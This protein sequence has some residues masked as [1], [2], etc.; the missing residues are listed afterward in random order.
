MQISLRNKGLYRVT[1]GREFKPQQH[2][3]K[4]KYLNKLNEAFGFVCIHISREL[5]FHLERLRTLKEVWEKLKYLFGKHDELRGH[6]L[7]NELIALQPNN[8]KTIQWFFSK[9]ISLV[10][11]C[12]QCGIEKKDEQLVLSIL[13]KLGSEFSVFV[14]TFHSMRLTP[15]NW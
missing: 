1:M 5:L 15:P 9:F 12:K 6:I 8:F 11:Q 14:S 7:E 4:S 2:L 13:S 10:M 3:E